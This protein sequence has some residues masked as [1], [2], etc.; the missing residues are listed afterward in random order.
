M[1][2]KRLLLF[3]ILLFSFF[4]AKA[5]TS[6]VGIE[7]PAFYGVANKQIFLE[8]GGPGAFLSINYDTR[9]KPD[10]RLGLGARVGLGFIRVE[11]YYRNKNVPVLTAPVSLNYLF[12]GEMSSSMFELGA[13]C[14]LFGRPIEI[15]NKNKEPKGD[16][17]SFAG[18]L[19]FMYRY[20]PINRGLSFR[21]G[22]TTFITSGGIVPTIAL[23]VGFAF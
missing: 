23:S 13:G 8:Y 11:D 9:F 22:L 19:D 16:E 3:A 17:N 15:Y 5:Q 18:H 7:D 12:G 10:K 1:N 2:V 20:S 14:T 21:G 6:T 4:T